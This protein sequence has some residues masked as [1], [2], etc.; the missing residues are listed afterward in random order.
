MSFDA[1]GDLDLKIKERLINE[2]LPQKFYHRHSDIDLFINITITEILNYKT[3]L[4]DELNEY[5]QKNYGTNFKYY[6]DIKEQKELLIKNLWNSKKTPI[7][8]Q[9]KYK[10]YKDSILSY[11]FPEFEVYFVAKLFVDGMERMPECYTKLL[12]NSKNINQYISMRFK[13]KDLTIDSYIL[14]E[15]YSMQ[16][17]SDKNLLG[18]TKIYLFDNNLNLGQGRHIFKLNKIQIEKIEE[19]NN[20]NANN[21]INDNTNIDKNQNNEEVNVEREDQLD[22]VGKEIDSLINSFY[23]KEFSKSLDYYGKLSEEDKDKLEI[24]GAK[25]SEIANYYYNRDYQKPLLKTSNMKQFD[26]KLEELLRQTDNS[27]V[28]IKFPSFKN[29]IIYEEAVSKNYKK[30][31]KNS[32][33][34]DFGSKEEEQKRPY[35]KYTTWVFDPVINCSKKDY[36]STENPVENKFSILTRS[37]DDDLIARDIRLNPYN[38]AQINEVLNNPDF[39]ELE[40]KNSTLFWSHRYELLKKN[41]PYALTKI[42]N[43]VKWGDPKSENE[44]IKNILTPWKTVEICDILYMLSRKFSVNKLY[45]NTNGVLDNFDGMKKIREYAIKKLSEHSNE[46]LNFI[47]LQLVQAI[48][49][50]DIS[51]KNVNSPLVQ[52]LIDRCIKDKVLSSSFYWF[53]ECESDKSEQTTKTSEINEIYTLIS[54]KF[55]K[56]LEKYP[57]NFEIIKNESDFKAELVKI[58]Q[59]LSKVS[60]VDNKKKELQTLIETPEKCNLQEKEYY[61]PFDP[62][63]KVKGTI[64]SDCTVFKSAKCPVKYTFKVTPDTKE[65]NHHEDKDHMRIMFKY[66]DDLRQDQLILQMINYMDSLLKNVHLDYEFTT[67]KTLA[68]SKSDGFVEFVPDSKTIFDIKKSYNNQIRAYYEKISENNEEELNKKL[69]SYVNSCAGY[70]VVTYI[71]GIGDRHL[72]N[73][74]IDKNGRLFHID[75]GYILGKDPKP[76][77]PP[78]KLCKEMVECMGGKGS[79]RYEEFQQKCVNAYWVLRDN[80]RVIVNMFYLMIDS[81]IPELNN[82]DNLKKLHEKFVPQKSRQEASNYMLD[83]LRESVDAMMPVFMEKL[84]AW[85]QYWK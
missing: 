33:R 31:F 35:I 40:S 34:F 82:I 61:L 72:E 4:T 80:A 67:Y 36:T 51:S 78:I 68:T 59:A 83:N 56:D 75:F 12:Y 57:E 79:K 50:E 48:R 42:M 49:Y 77:P 6:D 45:P 81:G 66:G 63:L 41:T 5:I 27:Y 76:M 62:R 26:A 69:D 85:A 55:Y 58:S 46:D 44:F 8:S 25:E 84:H 14:L 7:S 17:P 52:F 73:L 37:N 28:V 47:L 23:D 71:L 16:L 18:T 60:R 19:N 39:M 15:L 11:D 54:E 64:T 43:S 30:V 53:I 38:R 2:Y 9:L 24:K 20:E 21:A 22:G 10:E 65:F 70:C 13:Y 29:T 1:F 32:Y 74:M 3:L